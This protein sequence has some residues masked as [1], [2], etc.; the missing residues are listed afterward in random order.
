MVTFAGIS[1]KCDD[2]HELMLPGIFVKLRG[3]N[4]HYIILF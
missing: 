2:G 4:K 1:K 3:Q